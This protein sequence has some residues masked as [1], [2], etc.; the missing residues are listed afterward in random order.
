MSHFQRFFVTFLSQFGFFLIFVS[1]LTVLCE[2]SDFC[3]NFVRFLR[4]FATYLLHFWNHGTNI[5]YEYQYCCWLLVFERCIYPRMHA[6]CS[7]DNPSY[8][9]RFS[10][11]IFPSFVLDF[12]RTICLMPF[13]FS[14]SLSLSLLS[15]YFLCPIE[16][17]TTTAAAAER[18]RDRFSFSTRFFHMHNQ[19][20]RWRYEVEWILC[21]IPHIFT[22]PSTLQIGLRRSARQ[23]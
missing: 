21:Q 14:L 19:I 23:P 11:L 6:M 3:L 5:E 9:R 16:G 20:S 2:I 1:F 12:G 22:R 13:C 4:I 15:R 8:E 7:S 18:E 10:L 17:F